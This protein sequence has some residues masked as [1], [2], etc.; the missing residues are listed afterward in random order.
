LDIDAP[1]V[2]GEDVVTEDVI[3]RGSRHIDA[4]SSVARVGA[5]SAKGGGRETV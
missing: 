4:N 2:I 3:V 5:C 1:I